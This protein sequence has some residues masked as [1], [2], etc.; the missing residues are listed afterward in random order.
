MR[1][2]FKNGYRSEEKLGGDDCKVSIVESA[3]VREQQALSD[4]VYGSGTRNDDCTATVYDEIARHLFRQ[5][6][7][8]VVHLQDINCISL[9]QSERLSWER[10]PSK[11]SFRL[12]NLHA[13]AASDV[14]SG[15]ITTSTLDSHPAYVAL[16]YVW[17]SESDIVPIV[18]NKGYVILSKNLAQFLKA[19]RQQGDCTLIWADEL[20]INQMDAAEIS[21][22][23]LHVGEIFKNAREI[24]LW[25]RI[26]TSSGFEKSQAFLK[27]SIPSGQTLWRTHG[28][29]SK[30]PD[31]FIWNNPKQQ[32][33][34]IERSCCFS[35]RVLPSINRE[36][37]VQCQRALQDVLAMSNDNDFK[38][39]ADV[40]SAVLSSLRPLTLGE[41]AR[42]TILARHVDIA[43]Q[44]I[45]EATKF[46]AIQG[47]H[48]HV[49]KTHL[50]H[51]FRTQW[52]PVL[53][54]DVDEIVQPASM[55]MS[56]FLNWIQ[57][58]GIRKGHS[59]MAVICLR[60]LGLSNA[61]LQCLSTQKSEFSEYCTSLTDFSAYCLDFWQTHYQAAQTLDPA[62]STRLHSLFWDDLTTVKTSDQSN[63]ECVDSPCSVQ[64]ESC[65]DWAIL[66]CERRG[67]FVLQKAYEQMKSFMAQKSVSCAVQKYDHVSL[68]LAKALDEALASLR[69]D[70]SRSII[71]LDQVDR[72]TADEQLEKQKVQRYTYNDDFET[73]WT[74]ISYDDIAS[75]TTG[76][77]SVMLNDPEWHDADT[78]NSDDWQML[79][80]DMVDNLELAGYGLRTPLR[81]H[82][83]R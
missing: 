6:T 42:V 26:S 28:S 76:S 71:E 14:L 24:Y 13:G 47:Q 64:C 49:R 30:K 21:T 20:C 34:G 56:A 18:T 17:G 7:E 27:Q 78:K 73:G 38:L 23:M 80:T 8:D 37:F 53:S 55:C 2:S 5:R 61:A 10:L 67:F 19:I 31:P 50:Q 29:H 60:E 25:Q 74:W 75:N 68:P 58:P 40:L 63:H 46:F 39:L 22:Q 41:I 72:G 33:E 81:G 70:E 4:G 1:P 52:T 48:H 77:R 36:E 11:H 57:I 35:G 82:K 9:L 32:I 62:L 15:E 59:F 66:Y 44:P 45:D 43:T 83:H 65:L 3:S 16:S 69:L 51:L 54:L 79:E 12:L